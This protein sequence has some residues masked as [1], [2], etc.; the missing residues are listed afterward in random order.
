MLQVEAVVQLFLEWMELCV[1]LSM[2]R[3]YR[4][5]SVR[6]SVYLVTLNEVDF[7]TDK[8]NRQIKRIKGE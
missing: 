5:N 7:A 2:W 1:S 4:D 8:D 6:D 3:R